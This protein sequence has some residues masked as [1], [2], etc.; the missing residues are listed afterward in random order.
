MNQMTFLENPKV[1][2]ANKTILPSDV[3][4][5]SEQARKIL[6]R[7]REGPA[8]NIE[9][10]EIAL[11]YSARLHELKKCGVLTFEKVN[12]CGGVW[13]YEAR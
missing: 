5:I 9:L 6:E 4:R 8:T 13:R 2:Q 12:V 7:L 1:W 3:P 10:Q 11:R